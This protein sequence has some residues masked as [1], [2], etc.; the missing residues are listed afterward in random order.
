VLSPFPN[1]P[2][3][4]LRKNSFSPVQTGSPHR[5]GY[6]PAPMALALLIIFVAVTALTAAGIG[7]VVAAGTTTGVVVALCIHLIGTVV[8]LTA[9]FGALG[10]DGAD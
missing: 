8:V 2:K 5:R 10:P 7:A 6:D 3:P 9:I 1:L 4:L